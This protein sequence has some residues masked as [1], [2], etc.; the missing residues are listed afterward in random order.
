[1]KTASQGSSLSRRLATSSR[2]SQRFASRMQPERDPMADPALSPSQTKRSSRRRRGGRLPAPMTGRI[3]GSSAADAQEETP[4]AAGDGRGEHLVDHDPALRID[5]LDGE[6][7]AVRQEAEGDPGAAHDLHEAERVPARRRQNLYG[8]VRHNS[9]L[10]PSPERLRQSANASSL[11]IHFAAFSPSE[12]RTRAGR[13]I[14]FRGSLER[15]VR[16][17]SRLRENSAIIR[18]ARLRTRLGR[19]NCASAP[20]RA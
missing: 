20:L 13:F 18:P 14:G 11:F 1:M 8:R 3:A 15:P 12:A 10:A 9:S 5:M 16:R 19:P 2:H 7:R 4:H 6:D 17:S